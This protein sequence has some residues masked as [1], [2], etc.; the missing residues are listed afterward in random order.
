MNERRCGRLGQ[1]TISHCADRA[2]RIICD[3]NIP[4]AV[5]LDPDGRVTVEAIDDA[6]PD[7]MVGV[8]DGS[9]GQFELWRM[10]SDD[11]L[12]AKTERGVVGGSYHRH[13]AC[14]KKRAA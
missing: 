9:G 13:R 11:L 14:W 12:A 5:C 2:A 6:I 7:E 1:H 3:Y 4:R 10:I 8:Y